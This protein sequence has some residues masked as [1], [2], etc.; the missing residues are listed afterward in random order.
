MTG[1]LGW[2]RVFRTRITFFS[3]AVDT[4]TAITIANTKC[5]IGFEALW[6]IDLY[7][8]QIK[9]SPKHSNHTL[10]F[11]GWFNLLY[12]NKLCFNKEKSNNSKNE[13]HIYSW[14][15][16]NISE[17]LNTISAQL[18]SPFK[19]KRNLSGVKAKEFF[20]DYKGVIRIRLAEIDG[21]NL[22]VAE[23]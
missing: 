10:V 23:S 8:I 20:N 11:D 6:D 22:L 5:D 2:A 17:F 7:N 16:N 1:K 13:S 14:I 12:I 9:I 18:L 15:C 21:H 19:F 3:R 4:A